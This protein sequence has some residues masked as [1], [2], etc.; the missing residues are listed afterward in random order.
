M[1]RPALDALAWYLD[2]F[3]IDQGIQSK[4]HSTLF[5]RGRA[6]PV[7][8]HFAPGTVN[9][10]QPFYIHAQQC[11]A[12]DLPV[13]EEP[14][15]HRYEQVLYVGTRNREENTNAI[16]HLLRALKPGGRFILSLENQ[17]GAKSLE[18]ELRKLPYAF[19]S[20][21][22]KKCRIVS[23]RKDAQDTELLAAPLGGES[24]QS[25]I[26]CEEIGYYSHPSLFGWNKVDEASQLLTSLLPASLGKRGAELGS[27]YGYIACEVLS[28]DLPPE[29]FSLY[30]IEQAGVRCTR[31][32][33]LERF[34]KVKT[35]SYWHDITQ[36]LHQ[37]DLDFIISNP[38]FHRQE[39]LDLTLGEAFLRRA[40]QALRKD[41]NFYLVFNQHLPY[42]NL[43]RKLFRNVNILASTPLFTAVS[44][45]K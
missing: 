31:K 10:W 4:E 34:P 2:Q 3:P 26:F 22:K 45:I 11:I 5:A 42:Q 20:E 35:E 36:G 32:N 29:Q 27:G 25:P 17:L 40:H 39:K 18:K 1:D 21:S 43:L 28:H 23:L 14:S 33:I 38:P 6:H 19:E 16:I 24:I 15:I 8:Q 30:E 7:L 44:A 12:R 13:I 9:I 41:G 37:Q